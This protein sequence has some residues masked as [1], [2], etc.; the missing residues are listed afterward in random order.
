[1]ERKGKNRNA[2]A[3]HQTRELLNEFQT[4]K[5]KGLMRKSYFVLIAAASMLAS[6][7][8]ETFLD[9][10]VSQTPIGFTSFSEK[11]T[12]A[13]AETDL[14]FFHNTFVV[15]GTKKSTVDAAIS[16]VFD[17]GATSLVTFSEGAAAPNDWTYSPYRYWDKQAN[18]KFIAVA[19]NTSIIKY[20]W[21]KEA[22][23]L[24]EVGDAT[25]DFVTV[26]AAGYTLY[27]QN[28]QYI[29]TQDE[30]KKG[31]TTSDQ[32]TKKDVDLMTSEINSQTGSSHDTDVNLEFKHILAKLN[33]SVAKAQVLNDADVYVR[34]VEITKLN[35]NGKYAES[36]YNATATTPV[37]GWSDVTIKNAGYKLS[38]AYDND[39]EA[40]TGKG[41][42]LADFNTTNNKTVPN[43]FIESLVM[44]QDVPASATDQAELILKYTIV[45]GSGDAAHPEDYTY[46]FKLAEAFER[47]YDRCNYTLVFTI[48]PTVITF[49]ATVAQWGNGGTADPVI[50]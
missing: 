20:T 34:S 7:S 36:N 39:T 44:P 27:G 12:K 48:N 23:P 43:Y 2:T 29:S 26:A 32:T 16:S 33:V 30:I 13:I 28:L 9:E 46:K 21:D 18:Y 22:S 5:N 25:Y 42:E 4:L 19:P 35:D 8:N 6:C 45:T 38:Y 1:M 37:S 40:T 24:K 14:E 41:K 31:F 47:F 10:N 49:D 17:G 50:Y 11:L 3:F 15:Y